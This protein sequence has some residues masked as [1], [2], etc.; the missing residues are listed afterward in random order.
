M[1]KKIA[2][3]MLGAMLT[4]SMA[5]PAIAAPVETTV[6]TE[7]MNTASESEESVATIAAADEDADDTVSEEENDIEIVQE[8]TV[9]TA[10]AA[11]ESTS[12]SESDTVED[13]ED[14]EE[15]DI[16]YVDDNR[17]DEEGRISVEVQMPED[18]VFPYNI[19]LSGDEGDVTF[20]ISYNGQLLL[21]KPGTYKVKSVR[22]GNNKK[23]DKGARL[24]ITDETDAIYLNF[25]NPDKVKARKTIT[26]F[27]LSN[28]A[29]G[30]LIALAYCAF[31]K[32]CTYMGIKH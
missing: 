3:Y 10:K 20:E 9:A 26:S 7:S 19:T 2:P 21:I 13:T 23:L 8:E 15:D 27:V 17:L 32:Y 22:N 18:A 25:T 24:T 11:A 1:R 6:A 16:Q 5:T 30:L 14:T 4:F 12:V 31:R 29:W 28:I